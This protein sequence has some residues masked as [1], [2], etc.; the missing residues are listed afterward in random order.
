MVVWYRSVQGGSAYLCLCKFGLDKFRGLRGLWRSCDCSGGGIFGWCVL[1]LWGNQ[2]LAESFLA[3]FPVL[4]LCPLLRGRS[5]E[6]G[7]PL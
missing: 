7:S 3:A 6:A 5:P 4:L 1:V 2:R